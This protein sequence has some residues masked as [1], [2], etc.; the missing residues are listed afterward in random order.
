[1]LNV[2]ILTYL[3]PVKSPVTSLWLP[4]SIPRH[5]NERFINTIKQV[6]IYVPILSDFYIRLVDIESF[7]IFL[8]LLFLFMH[9]DSESMLNIHNTHTHTCIQAQ[10]HTS[11]RGRTG[12][13]THTH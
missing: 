7:V 10:I 12:A 6:A 9:M 3:G 11:V 2:C 1:M 8:I 5:V 13:H 4:A